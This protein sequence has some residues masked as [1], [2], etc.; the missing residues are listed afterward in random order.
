MPPLPP[1]GITS[2][3]ELV[4][5]YASVTR[6]TAADQALP[7]PHLP[8]LEVL[9]AT[10]AQKITAADRLHPVFTSPEASPVTLNALVEEVRLRPHLD[11]A[12]VL[13]WVVPRSRDMLLGACT[14]A[15]I[16]WIQDKGLTRHGTCNAPRCVDVYI[17]SSR[18]GTRRYC[19]DS[20]LNRDRVAIWRARKRSEREAM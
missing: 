20:C 7:Y 9:P 15:L 3:V 8:V 2:V 10:K 13:G 16:E 4:N 12:G 11:D 17:D 1:L 19:S 14:A 6:L 18:P 5:Q